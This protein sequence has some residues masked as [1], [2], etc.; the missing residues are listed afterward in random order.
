MAMVINGEA[1]PRKRLFW[2]PARTTEVAVIP[3]PT[4]NAPSAT[5]MKPVVRPP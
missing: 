4:R 2:E 5:S 3:E 1:L